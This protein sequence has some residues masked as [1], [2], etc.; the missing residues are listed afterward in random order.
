MVIRNRSYAYMYNYKYMRTWM[1][2]DTKA[3]NASISFKLSSRLLSRFIRSRSK[4]FEEEEER[5]RENI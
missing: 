4:P 2:M 3:F 1:C 5:E